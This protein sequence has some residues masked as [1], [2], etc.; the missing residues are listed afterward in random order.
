[1][2]ITNIIKLFFSLWFCVR[3]IRFFFIFGIKFAWGI[4]VIFK[5]MWF[6]PVPYRVGDAASKIFCEKLV[7]FG[8]IW[9]DLGKI[10]AK[11]RRN[12]GKIETK[13]G[14]K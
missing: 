1:M 14:Q 11:L 8:Q 5:N 3:I 9:L 13:F 12:L 6:V 10:C 4:K 7:G 2:T